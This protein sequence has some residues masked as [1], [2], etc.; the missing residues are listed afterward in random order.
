[1]SYMY[2]ILSWMGWIWAAIFVLLLAIG[3][4]VQKVRHR[5]VR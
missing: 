1:M 3:L 4:I 2:V 5:D